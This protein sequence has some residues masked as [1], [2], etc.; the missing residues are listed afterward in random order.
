[1]KI[2]GGKLRGQNFYMPVGTRPTQDVLRAAIFNIIGQDMTGLCFLELCA[3]SGAMSFE[4]ISRG[5]AE[6]VIVEKDFK[7]ASVIRENAEHLGLTLG[8]SFSLVNAD[9]IVAVKNLSDQ[10]RKFD[11]IFLD[12]PFGRRLA[13]KILKMVSASDI[14]KGQSLIIVQSDKSERLEMPLSM[15]IVCD[16]FYGNSHL[17]VLQRVV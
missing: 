5:A 12:P 4:A 13:K 17:T 1:M 6:A 11:V 15:S 16:R 3:G 7:N 2:L 9:A 10:K 8:G 14:L